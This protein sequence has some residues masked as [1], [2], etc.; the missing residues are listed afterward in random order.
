[1]EIRPVFSLTDPYY[2]EGKTL[3]VLMHLKCEHESLACK[4][5]RESRCPVSFTEPLKRKTYEERQQTQQ[6]IQKPPAGRELTARMRITVM[7]LFI[8]HRRSPVKIKV[9]DGNKSSF[10][11]MFQE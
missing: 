8:W 6:D 4:T 2:G 11:A 9:S 1:M 3:S 5:G 7:I 10:F